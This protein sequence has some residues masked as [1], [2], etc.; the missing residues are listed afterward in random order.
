MNPPTRISGKAG[1]SGKVTWI[2]PP[3]THNTNTD[4]ASWS[5]SRLL[6]IWLHHLE[7][8]H[9]THRKTGAI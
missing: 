5:I 3:F 7:C 8:R 9:D 2:L 4:E 6:N 1:H